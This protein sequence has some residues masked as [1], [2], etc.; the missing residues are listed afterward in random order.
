MATM[1][2]ANRRSNFLPGPEPT[3][4]AIPANASAFDHFEANRF[5]TP[6]YA[7]ARPESSGLVAAAPAGE[8]ARH[9]D[10]AKKPKRSAKQLG[11]AAGIGLLVIALTVTGAIFFKR[12]QDEKQWHV[13]APE[14][15]VPGIDYHPVVDSERWL[16]KGYEQGGEPR[17][18]PG[19]LLGYDEKTR[20]Y[21]VN[22]DRELVGFDL[23][24]GQEKWRTPVES[25]RFA[26]S[27]QII[28]TSSKKVL[29]VNYANGELV[30]TFR[31]PEGYQRD[32]LGS[33]NGVDFYLYNDSTYEVLA[34]RDGQIVWTK[35]LGPELWK[36]TL[37]YEK[38]GCDSAAKLNI[39]DVSSGDI[40]NSVTG[41]FKTVTW[42]SDGYI[43]DSSNGE[44]WRHIYDFTGTDLGR[45]YPGSLAPEGIYAAKDAAKNDGILVDAEGRT[46]VSGDLFE[47]KFRNG[48]QAPTSLG[49]SPPRLTGAPSSPT[50]L[51]RS[52]SSTRTAM[53]FR[54][55]TPSQM[56]R[57]I[58]I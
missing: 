8:Q 58:I 6:Q 32:F 18:I 38:I 12:Y 9:P 47:K 37:L 22:V 36:C 2:G 56:S 3:Q 28:C 48:K 29:K 24:S 15:V 54:K 14:P 25:C 27:G 45:A 55:S 17:E 19:D 11:L 52:L 4:A 39:L 41:S 20:I 35:T 44:K 5:P 33:R 13:N 57:S 49:S 21:V 16:A 7:P 42:L 1:S 40:V 50:I 34:V 30:T 26:V 51:I 46:L 23:T 10:A 43:S 31:P 53:S